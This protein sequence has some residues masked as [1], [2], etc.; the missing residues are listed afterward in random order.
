M[1]RP[2]CCSAASRRSPPGSASA[3][4]TRPPLSPTSSLQDSGDRGVPRYVRVP[5]EPPP[6]HTCT[7]RGCSCAGSWPRCAGS[8]WSPRRAPGRAGRP[9]RWCRSCMPARGRGRGG[10]G[11]TPTPCVPPSLLT[12]VRVD[13]VASAGS[14]PRARAQLERRLCRTSLLSTTQKRKMR[15]PWGGEGGVVGGGHG[16][17]PRRHTRGPS[18]TGWARDPLQVPPSPALAPQSG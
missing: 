8:P 11:G 5:R 9:R 18:A 2:C 13:L 6:P 1:H 4:C 14:G 16:G 12:V 15:G 17:S 7:Q 3:G 10:C